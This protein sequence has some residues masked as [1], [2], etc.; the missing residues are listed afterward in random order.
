MC[1]SPHAHRD[2]GSPGTMDVGDDQ[3]AAGQRR[4]PSPGDPKVLVGDGVGH[5]AGEQLGGGGHHLDGRPFSRAPVTGHE[6]AAALRD[7]GER[8][9][10]GANGSGSGS[11]KRS[12]SKRA[13]ASQTRGS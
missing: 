7:R 8:V 6:V 5:L 9:G 3:A 13:G 11:R 1:Q 10:I 4:D 12:G 2:V